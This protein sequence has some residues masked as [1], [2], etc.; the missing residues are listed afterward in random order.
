[1]EMLFCIPLPLS[2]I[3][4]PAIE[5]AL[6]WRCLPRGR[7]GASFRSA[8]DLCLVWDHWRR[9][10]AELARASRGA[11]ALLEHAVALN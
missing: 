3:V 10:A 2:T 6:G 7:A 9:R 1:M 4:P 11:T 8:H 5:T